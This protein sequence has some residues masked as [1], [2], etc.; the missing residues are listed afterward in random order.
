MTL[1]RFMKFFSSGWVLEAGIKQ[2]CSFRVLANAEEC[3]TLSL[4][5]SVGH[6]HVRSFT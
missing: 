4:N 3:N 2:F 6:N 1:G 5:V